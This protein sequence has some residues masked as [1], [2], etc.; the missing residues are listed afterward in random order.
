MQPQPIVE[1]EVQLPLQ[2]QLPAAF[3]QLFELCDQAPQLWCDPQPQI[4]EEPLIPLARAKLTMR[5]LSGAEVPFNGVMEGVGDRGRRNGVS[6]FVLRMW[7]TF[8]LCA[9][10]ARRAANV[11]RGH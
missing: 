5:T 10:G 3:A 1:P 6:L 8:N 7:G 2:I 11:S 4:I 9:H